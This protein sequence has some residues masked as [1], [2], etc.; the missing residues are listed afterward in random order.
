[1]WYGILCT[2]RLVLVLLSQCMQCETAGARVHWIVYKEAGRDPALVVAGA[3]G[4]FGDC[5]S[6]FPCLVNSFLFLVVLRASNYT[7]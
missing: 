2:G 3:V 5:V 7:H 1:M 6:E 4:L